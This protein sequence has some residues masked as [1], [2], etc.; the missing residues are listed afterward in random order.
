MV[1]ILDGFKRSSELAI[2]LAESVTRIQTTSFHDQMMEDVRRAA[3]GFDITDGIMEDAR[4]AAGGFDIASEMLEEQRN[5]LLG[6]S[7]NI[8]AM[9][10][11]YE[12]AVAEITKQLRDNP[13]SNMFKTLH[14][15]VT[16]NSIFPEALT[17]SYSQIS[18]L[19]ANAN[20]QATLIGE[21][22]AELLN[23]ASGSYT[24]AIA[25]QQ[26]VLADA[27]KHIDGSSLANI[28]RELETSRYAELIQPKFLK[29]LR[30]Q[31]DYVDDET[32]F[33]D[34]KD[35]IIE[36]LS[37]GI[38]IKQWSKK[39]KIIFS[40]IFV[41]LATYNIIIDAYKNTNY[42][43][44]LFKGAKTEKQVELLAKKAS[45][46]L[47][48][49]DLVEYRVTK[50]RLK[51]RPEPNTKLEEIEILPIGKVLFI[52]DDSRRYWLKVELTFE[53]QTLVG[54]VSKRFT[55]KLE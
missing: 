46:K 4:R 12:S 20:T 44:D 24:T 32:L 18:E 49:N 40:A 54:W 38:D 17:A 9:I 14:A 30:D 26:S 10:E 51:L 39:A 25:Q 34:V 47:D 3:R 7:D 15:E 35:E 42:L 27:M 1:S 5:R 48:I 43:I 21:S 13:L 28:F 31:D 16:K 11:P 19:A 8:S 23:Q 52:V 53:D 55:K 41:I 37:S 50:R 2:E 45:K 29:S 36:N 6:N 33:V 22:T